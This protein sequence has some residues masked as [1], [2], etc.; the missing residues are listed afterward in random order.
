MPRFKV[1]KQVT[2]VYR[3][4][5]L[6]DASGEEEAERLVRGGSSRASMRGFSTTPGSAQP[7]GHPL[8]VVAEHAPEGG[9][10]KY[11]EGQAGF[12]KEFCNAQFLTVAGDDHQQV[13]QE[14]L[15]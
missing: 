3:E 10:F 7:A 9:D 13:L 4:V 1:V 12:D 15:S 2:A 8:R 6:V 11:P 14:I 5:H